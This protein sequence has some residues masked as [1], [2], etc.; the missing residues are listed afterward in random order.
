MLLNG[1]GYDVR[2]VSAKLHGKN[3]FVTTTLKSGKL[4]SLHLIGEGDVRFEVLLHCEKGS[5]YLQVDMSDGYDMGFKMLIDGI[6]TNVRPLTDEQLLMPVK[7]L[8]AIDKSA[9]TNKEIEII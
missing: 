4:I 1:F 7:V 5:R 3:C 9:R 6:K 2:T 8:L